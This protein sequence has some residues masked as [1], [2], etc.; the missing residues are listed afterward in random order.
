M[1][2][3]T[4]L[5]L[6]GRTLENPCKYWICTP[7]DY[8]ET[9]ALLQAERN[10]LVARLNAYNKLVN[11][12][13]SEKWTP[14]IVAAYTLAD[15]TSYKL[16][17][18]YGDSNWNVFR[19]AELIETPARL[20]IKTANDCH[21]ATCDVDATLVAAGHVVPQEPPP[22]KT[23]ARIEDRILEFT[24]GVAKSALVVG[25]VVLGGL[26]AFNRLTR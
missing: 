26:Y 15:E 9:R 16:L 8:W 1:P 22:P 17:M 5:D 21:G 4:P 3:C 25:G 6:G 14:A 12:P 2:E 11:K 13:G 19:S 23:P 7:W 10:A 18:D 24:L 20:F